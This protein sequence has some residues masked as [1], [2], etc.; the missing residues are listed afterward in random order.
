MIKCQNCGEEL[1]NNSV[2]CTN[3]G[4][5]ISQINEDGEDDELHEALVIIELT[6]DFEDE[7]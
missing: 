3:C 7:E 5:K 6:E 4:I 2:F 1:L